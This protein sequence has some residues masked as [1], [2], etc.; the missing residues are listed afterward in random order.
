MNFFGAKGEEE[1][2]ADTRNMELMNGSP[3]STHGSPYHLVTLLTMALLAMKVIVWLDNGKIKQ[4]CYSCQK[5]F[6][7]PNT[8]EIVT[9]TQINLFLLGFLKTCWSMENNTLL[10]LSLGPFMVVLLYI[11]IWAFILWLCV[12]NWQKKLLT[13]MKAN[14]VSS[15]EQMKTFHLTSISPHMKLSMKLKKKCI[16]KVIFSISDSFLKIS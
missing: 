13:Q 10:L 9:C 5:L 12:V 6:P 15:L 2:L 3:I 11:S 16:T 4:I 14:K 1:S 8:C 7:L